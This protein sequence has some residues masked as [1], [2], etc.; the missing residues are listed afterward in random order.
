M[1]RRVAIRGA[2]VAVLMTGVEVTAE[3]APK[4]S[5]HEAA[6][7]AQ[8]LWRRNALSLEPL[9]AISGAVRGTYERALTPRLSAVVAGQFSV[10]GQANEATQADMSED[11]ASSQFGFGAGPG[12]QY[13]FTGTAPE[14]LWAGLRLDFLYE[15]KS[16][17]QELQGQGLP[18]GGLE[19]RSFG[20]ALSYG[21][22]VSA[23]YSATFANGF[24]VQLGG[25]FGITRQTR[26]GARVSGETEGQS[27]VT[28]TE[29]TTT[30]F[31]LRPRVGIGYAF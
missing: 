10:A 5:S 30:V 20:G 13:Y 23:G 19:A 31:A 4:V 12:I 3:E 27:V 6:P 14:G 8:Q 29:L 24:L 11:L 18:E 22:T 25:E 26:P 1:W 17:S 15:L 2:V 16:F 9:P 21:T 28:S 7:P